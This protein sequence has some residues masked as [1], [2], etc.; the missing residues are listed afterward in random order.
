VIFTAGI[1]NEDEVWIWIC[2]STE[3]LT[4]GCN[5]AVFSS[6]SKGSEIV[7]RH[8]GSVVCPCTEEKCDD[9]STAVSDDGSVEGGFVTT[10]GR[11]GFIYDY[12]VLLP[13]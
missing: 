4:H 1:T 8:D 6:N 5:S 11:G 10:T 9:G 3:Q 7:G 13:G 12:A 2:T